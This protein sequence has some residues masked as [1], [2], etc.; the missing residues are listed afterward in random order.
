MPIKLGADNV[1][2]LYQG[3]NLVDA[4]FLGSDPADTGGGGGDLP[5]AP[6]GFAYLV[7]DNGEFYVGVGDA[8]IIAEV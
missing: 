1:D 3:V 6:E 2:A 5:E 8:F 7:N 4:V